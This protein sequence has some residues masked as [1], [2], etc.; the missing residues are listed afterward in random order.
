VSSGVQPLSEGEYLQLAARLEGI[1]PF[2]M[3][4]VFGL[5]HAVAVAPS[6]IPPN[7]WL[8]VL[9]PKGL[10]GLERSDVELFLGHISRL[11]SEIQDA[12]RKLQAIVPK[13]DETTACESFAAGY[14][15]GAALDPEW[16]GDSS[17]WT[18]A[19]PFAYLA[20]RLDFVPDRTVED[21]ERNL[22]P[23]PKAVLRR[24]LG[25]LVRAAAESFQMLRNSA[26]HVMS[27]TSDPS[28]MRTGRN[29]RA[30]VDQERSTSGAVWVRWRPRTAS[31][32][33]AGAGFGTRSEGRRIT[34]A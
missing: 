22:A 25:A 12:V 5:L 17:R 8:S 19:A 13:A 32:R 29:D 11:H 24:D 1:S 28:P 18:F 4:G 26:S 15:A 14:V 20:Q 27:R 21:I 3:D 6:L 9:V 34:H 31:S 16:L 7:A 2:D 10:N 23:D 33:S 30:L